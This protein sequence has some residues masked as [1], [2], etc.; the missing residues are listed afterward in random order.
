MG[1]KGMDILGRLVTQRDS[2]AF[3]GHCQPCPMQHLPGEGDL[4][5]AG[6]IGDTGDMGDVGD[7]GLMVPSEDELGGNSGHSSSSSSCSHVGSCGHSQGGT[8]C[9]GILSLP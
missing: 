9:T 4:G 3:T 2:G 8:A 1:A 7:V 6:D 5:D